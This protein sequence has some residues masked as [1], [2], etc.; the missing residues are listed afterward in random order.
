VSWR[1]RQTAKGIRD[2][3]GG[4]SGYSQA[5]HR[6]TSEHW[7]SPFNRLF[8]VNRRPACQIGLYSLSACMH[9]VLG[10]RLHLLAASELRCTVAI[11]C[12]C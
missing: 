1:L 7:P 4:G 5:T 10:H 2:G 9:S 12:R 6:E 11:R 8:V 3:G